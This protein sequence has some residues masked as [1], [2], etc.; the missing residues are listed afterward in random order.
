MIEVKN[1]LFQPLT[2]HVE[3]RPDGLHLGP[4]ERCLIE[5]AEASSEL[6][7]AEK[8]G[9]VSLEKQ[10]PDEA[11]KMKSTRRSRKGRK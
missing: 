6:R 7:L 5:P 1:L 11:P 8:R 10:K 3:G 4:R 2:L 9:L